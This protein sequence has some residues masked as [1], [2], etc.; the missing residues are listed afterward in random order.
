MDLTARVQ[1]WQERLGRQRSFR[2]LRPPEDD[3]RVG[4]TAFELLG[5]RE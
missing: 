2:N 3:Q 5:D 4:L 1:A